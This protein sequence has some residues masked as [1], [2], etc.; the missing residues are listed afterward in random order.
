LPAEVC[1]PS[2]PG[3]WHWLDPAT[4]YHRARSDGYLAFWS[5]AHV[6]PDGGDPFFREIQPVYDEIGE[7]LPVDANW[8][9]PGEL[10]D[11]RDEI[12]AS[13]L[14][15]DVQVRHYDW[16]VRHDAESYIGLLQTFS[17]HIAM[18]P[19]QRERLFS[20]IR[21]RLAQRPDRQLRRHWAAV[22]HVARRR[23]AG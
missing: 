20:A 9:R 15:H 23:P 1:R 4:R 3:L 18:A 7:G 6:F 11:H 12:E 13:G 19:W 14:F 21:H 22:L 5:A 8:P 10:P 2:R 17:G 16:Q